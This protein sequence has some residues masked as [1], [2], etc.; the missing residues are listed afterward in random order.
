MFSKEEAALLR[1]SFW[2][3]FGKSFPRKWIKYNTKIKDF[4]FKFFADNKKAMVMLDIEPLNPA[5][6]ELLY[7]QLLALKTILTNDYLPEV[8]FEKD[9]HLLNGKCISR[10]SVTL[11]EKFSIYNKDTWGVA[12]HFFCEKMEQFELFF[13]EYQD[14]IKKR[15]FKFWFLFLFY[16]F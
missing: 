5:K 10:I 11:D 6:R 15:I 12:F 14:F 3:S 2:V 1:K 16:D 13:Y 7:D 9:C 8:I 4:S